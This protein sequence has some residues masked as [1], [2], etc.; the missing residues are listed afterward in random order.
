MAKLD[1]EQVE[2]MKQTQALIA[3]KG[4]LLLLLSF[5]DPFCFLGTSN[6]TCLGN[7][8]RSPRPP[9]HTQVRE[10]PLLVRTALH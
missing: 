4:M 3:A 8:K 6:L 10:H 2:F 7:R 9:I 5:F 1:R